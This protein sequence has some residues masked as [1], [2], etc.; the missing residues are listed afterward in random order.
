MIARCKK[1]VV[2]NG[3]PVLLKTTEYA[4][5]STAYKAFSLSWL[6]LVFCPGERGEGVTSKRK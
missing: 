4:K 1:D 5:V 2:K 6:G 3:K